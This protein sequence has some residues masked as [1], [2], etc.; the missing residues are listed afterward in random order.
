MKRG[1]LSKDEKIVIEQSKGSPE[2][3]AKKLDR[4]VKAV[5]SHLAAIPKVAD[6]KSD[7][8]RN[9]MNGRDGI[10]IMTPSVSE[11]LDES[12][13]QKTKVSRINRTAIHKPKG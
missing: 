3:I 13:V 7:F 4:S 10:T 9:T 5:S 1:P 12:K 2:Q 6:P 8:I 11:V